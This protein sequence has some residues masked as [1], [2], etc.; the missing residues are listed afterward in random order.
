MEKKGV[1]VV[2]VGGNSLI[3]DATHKTIP[4]QYFAGMESM[5]HIVDMIDRVGKLL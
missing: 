2:A 4:D 3:K 5:K 1:A